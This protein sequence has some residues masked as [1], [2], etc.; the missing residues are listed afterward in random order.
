L[1]HRR[2]LSKTSGIAEHIPITAVQPGSRAS[3]SFQ[4]TRRRTRA[5]RAL[6][7]IQARPYLDRLLY[8]P[9]ILCNPVLAARTSLIALQYIYVSTEWQAHVQSTSIRCR[10]QDSKIVRSRLPEFV[11]SARGAPRLQRPLGCGRV[12]IIRV[13][14][15]DCV[16]LTY[17]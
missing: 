6:R 12:R 5:R 10:Q 2:L 8:F 3:P 7:Y 15:R 13:V 16:F 14:A 1:R 11:L 4:A 9:C 17:P